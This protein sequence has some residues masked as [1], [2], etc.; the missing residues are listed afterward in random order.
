MRAWESF[1]W[2]TMEWVILTFK[3]ILFY[4]KFRVSNLILHQS[5]TW[6]EEQ[7]QWLLSPSDVTAIMKIPLSNHGQ[8]TVKS[9]YFIALDILGR[10]SPL[11]SSRSARNLGS[12]LEG[13]RQIL[14]VEISSRNSATCIDVSCKTC[15]H[16]FSLHGLWF[17]SRRFMLNV[18]WF[19][20]GI[21]K[22]ALHWMG[23]Y[24]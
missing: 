3:S 23:C 20:A 8:F 22:H 4:S 2:V 1:T 19:F 7:L 21:W 9:A 17:S 6:N 15:S 24:S 11:V 12:H 14:H 13:H 5:M 10:P 18:F 16:R